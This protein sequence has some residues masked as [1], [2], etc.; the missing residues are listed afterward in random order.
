MKVSEL[1]DQLSV[2]PQDYPVLVAV[3]EEGN[4]YHHLQDVVAAQADLSEG[5]RI[6]SIRDFDDVDEEETW[7]KPVVV[8]YP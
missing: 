4:A 8:I 2:Y 6:E 7:Y 1:I 3:D 5:W